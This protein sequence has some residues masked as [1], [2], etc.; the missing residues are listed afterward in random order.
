MCTL[1]RHSLHVSSKSWWSVCVTLLFDAAFGY[2]SIDKRG[3]SWWSVCVTL[4]SDA[5]SQYQSIDNRGPVASARLAC[6]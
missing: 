6:R 3:P 4:L 2:Q 1:C 5:A